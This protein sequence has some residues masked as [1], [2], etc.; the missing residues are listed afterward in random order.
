[1]QFSHA[2][3]EKKWSMEEISVVYFYYPA[4]FRRY[5][6]TSVNEKRL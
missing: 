1:M 6:I 3:R 2:K 4:L 5:K